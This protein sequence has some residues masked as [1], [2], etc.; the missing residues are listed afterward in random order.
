MVSRELLGV[1]QVDSAIDQLRNRRARLAELEAARAADAALAANRAELDRLGRR[2]TELEQAVADAEEASAEIDR[3]RTRLQA[4]LKTVIAPRE[5]EALMHELDTL[6]ERRNAIDDTEL[7]HL[8]EESSLADAATAAADATPGLVDS[9]AATGA[10]LAAAEAEIDA[11]IAAF[12]A[13]LQG[14]TAAV[15]PKTLAEYA[16]RRRRQGGVAV[17]TLDGKTCSG[18][19]LDLSTSELEAVRQTPEG[20]LADCPQCGRWLAP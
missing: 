20:E 10:A 16:E 6:A 8:E 15:A 1:Q 5:A 9:A 11:E 17:A 18:C 2:R 3:H 7:E 4:Q 14:L 12:D 19:H 13:E